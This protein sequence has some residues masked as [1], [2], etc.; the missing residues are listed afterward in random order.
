MKS[1][2]LISCLL[3]SCS[4]GSLS[5]RTGEAAVTTGVQLSFKIKVPRQAFHAMAKRRPSGEEKDVL[6]ADK[7]TGLL[8]CDA[9]DKKILWDASE[10]LTQHVKSILASHSHRWIHDGMREAFNALKLPLPIIFLKCTGVEEGIGRRP[11]ILTVP[12]T[13]AGVLDK[14]DKNGK[15]LIL[16]A[17]SLGTPIV[18]YNTSIGAAIGSRILGLLDDDDLNDFVSMV[19]VDFELGKRRVRQPIKNLIDSHEVVNPMLHT[20]QT[21]PPWR[22][23]ENR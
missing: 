19:S 7:D 16:D 12:P 11:E 15:M 1:L 5:A 4:I 2:A 13:A 23:L 3:S 9:L 22:D 18:P 6:L 8:P 20:I 10:E 14:G 17:A 21:Q